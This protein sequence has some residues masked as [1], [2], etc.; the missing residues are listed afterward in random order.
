MQIASGLKTILNYFLPAISF[1]F[2]YY[3]PGAVQLYF[4]VSASL[5]YGQARLIN[6]GSFRNWAGLHPLVPSPQP[7]GPN[8]LLP[9]SLGAPLPTPDPTTITTTT[10]KSPTKPTTTTPSAAPAG[11]K[12]SRPPPAETPKTSAPA[13][14]KISVIDKIVNKAK[15]SKKDAVD[16]LRNMV[17]KGQ[18][19]TAGRRGKVSPEAERYEKAMAAQDD[20]L[21][22]EGK[23]G[24]LRK[25]L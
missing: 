18:S 5:A 6:S 16:G 3:Q 17:Q 2:M 9:L 19:T 23:K 12:L 15:S 8:D 21:R 1:F 25:R 22:R 13:Q 11:L 4:I 20:E 14:P 7:S 10:R 24:R